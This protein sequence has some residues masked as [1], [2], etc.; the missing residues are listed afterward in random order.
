M[1]LLQVHTRQLEEYDGQSAPPYAILSHT[2]EKREVTFQNISNPHHKSYEGYMKIDGC[3]RQAAKDGLEYVWIDT[4]CIDKSSSAELSEGINSMFQWYKNSA[5][6]YVYLSDVSTDD[7]PFSSS[8]EF[9]NSRWFTRGWTLQEL[10]APM[11]LVFFNMCW[12][13]IEIGR[14]NRSLNPY[15]LHQLQS[16]PFNQEQY[17]NRLGLLYLLSEI[18]NI[19]KTA[20]DTGDFSKFC[21]AARFAW[22][23][24]RETTR[25]EDRAYS[26]L[27]LLEVNMP[28]LYGEGNKAFRR[29]QE[30]VIKSRD[31]DSLLAWGYCLAP[32][33]QPRLCADSV[34]AP[35]PFD[36]KHCH[37]FQK[38][39][40]EETS[41]DVP[42]TIT[43][44][45]MTNIGMQMTIPLRLID[46]KNRIFIAILRCVVPGTYDHRNHLVVPLVRT[47]GGDKNHYSRAPGSLPFVVRREKLFSLIK[48]SKFLFALSRVPA[49]WKLFIKKPISTPIYLRGSF[50]TPPPPLTWL[51]SQKRECETIGLHVDKV[52]SAGY[53]VS[54]FYPPWIT[55]RLPNGN[56][57]DL[58]LG[59]S[60]PARFILVFS[61]PKRFETGHI[62]FAICISP[63]TR[64]MAKMNH[65]SAL[66]LLMEQSR[67]LEVDMDHHGIQQE[68]LEFV[69]ENPDGH[70]RCVHNIWF[71]YMFGDVRIKCSVK[72]TYADVSNNGLGHGQSKDESFIG[73]ALAMTSDLPTEKLVHPSLWKSSGSLN[74][75]RSPPN[76][77]ERI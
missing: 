21:V 20:L 76:A 15:R 63:N 7:T 77:P 25:L 37:S 34:L 53:E 36:F 17:R 65:G 12:D 69:E 51:K 49:L 11:E 64:R 28:L 39:E 60:V 14:I 19:P 43:H 72:D 57:L 26:L 74:S 27:G 50:P 31:D 62:F 48:G 71:E 16:A 1:R 8:S 29:L 35:S 5:I 67:D 32:K 54:S 47:K 56:C 68:E 3:C 4:C 46:P 42:L 6:C 24:D 75:H 9:R 33:T 73:K 18:T 10:L 45:A 55:R 40:I 13:E 61:R 70:V 44:S 66:E 38:L 22:A 23:A 41:P 2:W 30:E 59:S 58:R 52:I